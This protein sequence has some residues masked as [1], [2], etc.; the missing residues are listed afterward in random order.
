MLV[1][2]GKGQFFDSG[3]Y[4]KNKK[5][6][7][8]AASAND[9]GT[10]QAPVAVTPGGPAIGPSHLSALPKRMQRKPSGASRLGAPS[11]ESPPKD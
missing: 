10:S 1:M 3:E 8:G 7:G 9:S 2:Q 11:L 5:K 4:N 6:E